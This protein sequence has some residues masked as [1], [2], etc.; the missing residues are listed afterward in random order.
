MIIHEDRRDMET[1]IKHNVCDY[2]KENPGKSYAGCT[3]SGSITRSV[4]RVVK[5]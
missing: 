2:H 1:V 5:K 3:C 4:K